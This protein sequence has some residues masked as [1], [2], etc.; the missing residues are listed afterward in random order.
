MKRLASTRDLRDS[1]WG[2][3]A[4]VA[5]VALACGVNWVA[6]GPGDT[7]DVGMVFLL[8]VVIAALWF[9][10]WP[11]LLAAALSG[12]GFAYFFAPP[13][14]RFAISDLK[15]MGTF[16]VMLGVAVVVSELARRVRVQA[17]VSETRRIEAER[18]HLRSTLLSS[19]SHDLRTPLAAI[20]G[21][22]SSLA[23]DGDRLPAET[24][25]D[26]VRS[27][28]REAERLNGRVR[29]LL[30]MT[31]LES[32]AVSVQKEW[33]ALE[34]VIGAALM[35][36]EPVLAGREV[37]TRVP[38]NLPLVPMDAQLVE[39]VLVNLVENA[40]KYSAPGTPVE[41]GALARGS[42]V[43]IEVADRGPGIP[44]GD[45]ERMF[46]KFVRLGNGRRS[47]G[48]GLGLAICRAIVQLHGG[49]IGA[50]NRPGGGLVVRFTL[51]LEGTPPDLPP[52]PGARGTEPE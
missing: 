35:R 23:T 15:H 25:A 28:L 22:A 38:E 31:R 52:D 40:V 43:V 51:P 34:D 6:F 27:I 10:F 48:V 33:D 2:H 37:R 16:L 32:G 26:L 13:I 42:E 17:F 36:V 5:T 29:N 8:G 19:V 50:M 41:V 11:A 44:A 20:T 3:A 1:P 30:D 21:A 39:Q 49:T 9:G 12:A 46:Q 4:A 7:A 24:R 45:E 47:E 14:F 18:E